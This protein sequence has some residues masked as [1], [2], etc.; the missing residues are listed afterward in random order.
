MPGQVG[1][2]LAVQREF[3]DCGDFISYFTWKGAIQVLRNAVAEGWEG[4]G[5][6]RRG[7]RVSEGWE[8]VGFSGRKR[9]EGVQSNV[10]SIMRGWVGCQIS[11]KKALPNTWMAPNLAEKNCS[12]RWYSV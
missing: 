11:R 5:G 8:G 4:V 7:G 10:I 6:W 3:H 2:H 1:Y 12:D 9:Y